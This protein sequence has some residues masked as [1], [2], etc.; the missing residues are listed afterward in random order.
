VFSFVLAWLLLSLPLSLFVGRFIAAGDR[1][2]TTSATEPR[3]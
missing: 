3:H 1:R 2:A